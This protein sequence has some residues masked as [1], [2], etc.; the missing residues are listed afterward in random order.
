M[1][2]VLLISQYFPP[3][4]TAAA[5]RM[6]ALHSFLL[7]KGVDADVLTTTPHK[8]EQTNNVKGVKDDSQKHI[9]RVPVNSKKHVL[10]YLEFLVRTRKFAPKNT[11]Y[12]WIIVSSPPLSVFQVAKRFL[13]G[14]KIFLDIRDL[15]PDTPVAAGKMSQGLQYNFFKKY[16]RKMYQYASAISAV[17]EP[18]AQYI[19][20]LVPGKE[21]SVVYNGIPAEDLREMAR[22]RKFV[23]RKGNG[24]LTIAYAGNLGLLQGLEV[25]PEALEMVKDLKVEF[26][27]IGSGALEKTIRKKAAEQ[28]NIA[29]ISPMTRKE[30]LPFLARETD[31]LFINL[32]KDWILE[33]TIPS[34]LFDYLLL[35][36]PIIAGIKGAG[37]EILVETGSAVFFE[38]DSPSSL[39]EAIREMH[40]HYEIYAENACSNMPTIAKRFEREKQFSKILERITR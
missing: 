17:S 18:M 40:R 23:K 10:Q 21:V 35:G 36:K 26:A 34:K 13:P 24:K 3:D 32:K 16:E 25:V 19:K 9:F 8:F 15:W 12:D 2:K 28:R 38:Q 20:D 31:V 29:F 7:E 33:K 6:G 30:L 5:F 27:F 22:W 1:K 14:S 39:A 4:I 37:K 11:Q